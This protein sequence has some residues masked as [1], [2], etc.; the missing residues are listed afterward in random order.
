MEKHGTDRGLMRSIAAALIAALVFV[1]VVFGPANIDPLNTDWVTTGGGDNLQHYLGWRFFRN[2]PWSK[3]FLFDQEL[4]YPVGTSVIV[5]DSNPLL[6]LVFKL[7]RGVLPAQFQFNGIWIL[8]CYLLT[9]LFA[10]LILW[11]LT[12]RPLICVLGAMLA[13]LNPVILQRALIHDNLCAHWLI[14]AAVWLYLNR[15]QYV[16]NAVGWAVLVLL[17]LLIHFYFLPMIAFIL[18]LQMLRMILDREPFLR[19]FAPL[20]TFAIAFAAG[21]YAFG[22]RYVNGQSGSFGE[23]SMNL[24]AF[25][26]PD[27]AS[28]ILG[29]RPTLPLQYEGFNYFG[30]GMLALCLVGIILGGKRLKKFAFALLPCAALVLLAASN[31]G[32]FDLTQLWNIELPEALSSLLSVFR[33]SGRLVWPIYYLCL[34]ASLRLIRGEGERRRTAEIVIVGLCLMLQVVDLSGFIGE[35]QTRFH[36][37]PG[38]LSAYAEPYAD[39]IPAEKTKL[40]VTDGDT[41]TVDALALLAADRGLTFNRAANARGI[42]NIYHAD[43]VDMDAL[44]CVELDPDAAYIYLD[45]V[46]DSLRSCAEVS[47]SVVYLK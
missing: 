13:V 37:A 35:C 31:E 14:L 11:H 29:N 38:G 30:L 28:S 26:N 42:V 17:T 9:A 27:G 36:S 19:V 6:C 45:G 18:A 2:A 12:R 5:T 15:G 16:K 7:F 3:Q 21:Y 10:V 41:K 34:F 46:P 47:G 44:T 25:I 23:L 40:F 4:N 43:P 1:L 39:D 22:Y 8:S 20:L 33:S 24:N 32:W